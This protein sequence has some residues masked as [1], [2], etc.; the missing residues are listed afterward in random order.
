ME[1][2]YLSTNDISRLMYVNFLIKS[3]LNFQ[4][5]LLLKSVYIIYDK[6]DPSLFDM[7]ARKTQ[8]KC[9]NTT[10]L[11][12]EIQIMINCNAITF[13]NTYLFEEQNCK[14]FQSSWLFGKI[15]V[16]I[17]LITQK[18]KS[19]QSALS[20]DRFFE[21]TRENILYIFRI[22]NITHLAHAVLNKL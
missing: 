12:V 19:K 9:Q 2:S 16:L 3:H 21:R 11:L 20:C 8:S 7:S 15:S 4:S 1:T 18:L 14:V 10:F 6:Q 22:T 17:N 5:L 13:F